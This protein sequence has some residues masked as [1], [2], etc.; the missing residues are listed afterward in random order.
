MW[1]YCDACGDSI[2]KPKLHAHL[3]QCYTSGFSCIDCSRA[4]DTSSVHGHTSCVTEHEKYAQ[5]ATKP[6]GYAS[7]GFY[8]SDGGEKRSV[9]GGETSGG[10]VVGQM[11]LSTRAPWRCEAPICESWC[12][13]KCACHHYSRL[14]SHAYHIRSST[15]CQS[16][17]R[18]RHSCNTS[19]QQLTH[20]RT[21]T[22]TI[23]TYCCSH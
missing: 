17:S 16:D 9:D 5:G 6:G 23:Y 8:S 15:N 12:D 3:K 4:F 7:G 18:H 20:P 10:E 19:P 21:H 1:F 13:A 11:Y 14:N 2:K 22:G